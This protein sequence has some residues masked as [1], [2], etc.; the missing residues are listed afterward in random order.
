VNQPDSQASWTRRRAQVQTRTVVI[1]LALLLD[2]APRG[3]D[4]EPEAGAW[5]GA[6]G[7]LDA[8]VEVPRQPRVAELRHCRSSGVVSSWLTG[9]GG[10]TR[11]HVR[12]RPVVEGQTAPGIVHIA[13]TF[14]GAELY[15]DAGSRGV[16]QVAATAWASLLRRRAQPG[17]VVSAMSTMDTLLVECSASFDE[18][19]SAVEALRLAIT[20]DEVLEADV[21]DARAG[22]LAGM[23]DSPASSKYARGGGVTG[24]IADAV[25][26]ADD[27]RTRPVSK[28]DLERVTPE[29]VRAWIARHRDRAPVE[30]GIAGDTTLEQSLQVARTLVEGLPPRDRVSAESLRELRTLAPVVGPVERTIREPRTVSAIE[31]SVDP[32]AASPE[33][34]TQPRAGSAAIV[35]GFLGVDPARA[36]EF[37]AVRAAS[38]V[39]GQRIA[40][41]LRQA[42]I[43]DQAQSAGSSVVLSPFAGFG[44][45]TIQ[46]IVPLE[47]AP[48]ASTVMSDEVDRLLQEGATQDE[49]TPVLEQLAADAEQALDD[50]R[51]WSRL[52]A[53][54]TISGVSTR[55]IVAGPAFYRSLTPRTL[56]SSISLLWTRERRVSVVIELPD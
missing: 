34:V 11:V 54:S 36:G 35:V 33:G 30:I 18:V 53:R 37:R 17:A 42:G 21:A 49:L 32:D 48:A 50:Q 40:L 43:I 39:L 19:V 22:L 14:A 15:E 6:G 24:A 44:L 47:R 52:L 29:Q 55:D 45:M 56:E 9:A 27:A 5:S 28:S 20:T 16:S 12:A 13:M 10:G 31:R 4:A 2:G 7:R 1:A 41:R 51:A 25:F 46:S 38:R 26:P 8:Q 3:A 23:R